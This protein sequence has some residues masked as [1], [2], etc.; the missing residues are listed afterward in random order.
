MFISYHLFQNMS[1]DREELQ[2]GHISKIINQVPCSLAQAIMTFNTSLA[3]FGFSASV[4]SPTLSHFVSQSFQ[5]SQEVLVT[6]FSSHERKKL[7]DIYIFYLSFI[8]L[9]QLLLML[10]LIFAVHELHG[11]QWESHFC[12][13]QILFLDVLKLP[14][15]QNEFDIALQGSSPCGDRDI[16]TC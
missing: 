9:C 16:F 2:N 3:L 4:T 1:F 12:C 6:L 7:P 11:N 10:C 13:L 5:L 8:L 15:P 14:R